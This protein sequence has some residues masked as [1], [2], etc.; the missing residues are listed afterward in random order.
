MFTGFANTIYVRAILMQT[1][2]HFS[3]KQKT[4]NSAVSNWVPRYLDFKK[5]QLR[6]SLEV[7]F[8]WAGGLEAS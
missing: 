4:T 8:A 2:D 6:D 5:V 7:E 1:I 3:S